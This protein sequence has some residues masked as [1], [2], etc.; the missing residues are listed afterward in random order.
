MK[1]PNG[2]DFFFFKTRGRDIQEQ[3]SWSSTVVVLLLYQ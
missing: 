2:N 3:T 1:L